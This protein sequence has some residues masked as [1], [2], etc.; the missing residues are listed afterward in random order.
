MTNAMTGAMTGEL[1][2]R[3]EDIT[4]MWLS[5]A[6]AGPYPGVDVTRVEILDRREVTNAHARLAITYGTS[7]AGP[8]TVF[9]KLP[10][11]NADHRRAVGAYAMGVREAQFYA[12]LA[13]QLGIV[14]PHA[15]FAAYDD[16]GF[17]L[18]LDDLVTAGCRVSDGTWG[19]PP[20]DAASALEDLAGLHVPFADSGYRRAHA[21]WATVSK[22]T[23]DYGRIH[24][25]G[26]LRDHRERLSDS[27]A[28]VARLYLTQHDQL[29]ALWHEGP[30]TVIHGDPHIGNL[31]LDPRHAGRVGF[32]DW[33]IL[34]VN[35]PMRDVSYFLTMAMSIEDRQAHE[36]EL[37]RLYV[38]VRAA[39]G[40][41]DISF[42]DAWHAHRIHSAYTVPA[43][44][45]A[46]NYSGT[47]EARSIF[48]AAFTARAV[49]AL[50]D[51]D[52][53]AALRAAGIA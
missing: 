44:C 40:L 11:T 3:A 21:P 43:S 10:P 22:P 7:A 52:A 51:L 23:A 46:A 29:Q 30:H 41:H 8:P 20:D 28:E 15:H 13:P 35:T 45:A 6:L 47:N 32:L 37:I 12:T 27:Y 34:N 19:I 4:A 5:A 1:P 24:L 39:S 42:A 18:L 25:Q 53:V 2:T 16:R 50:D 14:S 31:Y 49:A 38:D 9:C 48:A 17:V 33:G 36:R 26:A